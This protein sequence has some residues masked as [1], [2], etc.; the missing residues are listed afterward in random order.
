MHF[1][2]YVGSPS[3]IQPA[4]DRLAI[5]QNY[6]CTK[7]STRT[8]KIQ[9]KFLYV[10]ESKTLLTYFPSA[11][12]VRRCTI[13][14]CSVS[15]ISEYLIEGSNDLFGV[16]I[17]CHPL[18]LSAD[19]DAEDGASF[20]FAVAR[21]QERN[22]LRAA[23]SMLVARAQA[24]RRIG[25][26]IVACFQLWPKDDDEEDDS[27]DD[28]DDD[29]GGPAGKGTT[30]IG[31]DVIYK[32]LKAGNVLCGFRRAEISEA[33]DL[34][35]AR[36]KVACQG[37]LSFEEGLPFPEV[38]RM[39]QS[40]WTLEALKDIYLHI[41][42]KNEFQPWTPQHVR[43]F[44]RELQGDVL[45]NEQALELTRAFSSSGTQWNFADFCA[46][47]C[48]PV[49][50]GWLP[51]LSPPTA[52]AAALVPSSSRGHATRHRAPGASRDDNDPAEAS[53][54]T[55][56]V[57]E[58]LRHRLTNYCI[59]T[60]YN[61]PVP[62]RLADANKYPP[63]PWLYA[64]ALRQG[65]RAVEV[66]FYQGITTDSDPLVVP[67]TFPGHRYTLRDVM[68]EI[69]EAMF[70]TSVL[71]VWLF[72]KPDP[73]VSEPQIIAASRVVKSMLG[74]SLVPDEVASSTLEGADTPAAFIKKAFLVIV[75]SSRA[76]Q[77]QS[78]L[79]LE[80]KQAGNN[81]ALKLAV[82]STE[83]EP[84]DN[85]AADTQVS[86]MLTHL[87]RVDVAF[88]T[89]L[90]LFAKGVQFA[91]INVAAQL[92]LKRSDPDAV[93]RQ[94]SA[95][96]DAFFQQEGGTGYILRAPRTGPSGQS[97]LTTRPGRSNVSLGVQIKVLCAHRLNVGGRTSWIRVS[98]K[99]HGNDNDSLSQVNSS[100]WVASAGFSPSWE[101][102]V[103]KV[104]VNDYT[105]AGVHFILEHTRMKGNAAQPAANASVVA[106]G[107]AA[108]GLRDCRLGYRAIRITQ[109]KDLDFL[110]D[111]RSRPNKMQELALNNLSFSTNNLTTDEDVENPFAPSEEAV[112]IIHIKFAKN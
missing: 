39:L 80:A 104:N 106:V 2:F 37:R 15:R 12:T 52:T 35:V 5:E 53:T 69:E 36:E 18:Q 6:P 40:L 79:N 32:I 25:R 56:N 66:V 19:D 34:S 51:S 44:C 26:M 17:L 42:L 61:F 70:A 54:P 7:V 41:T 107:E 4:I 82:E 59:K 94:S 62:T 10:D 112:L 20:I 83:N 33:F 43:A 28:V 97:I 9:S 85:S 76:A 99:L 16:K 74:A 14:L 92:E 75:S 96:V 64:Q 98:V 110:D 81:T 88:S 38:T 60:A 45:T 67:M 21:E 95:V 72:L 90:K 111:A 84:E 86:G 102:F 8:G 58:H 57:P 24:D 47:L 68:R 71:P 13:D 109:P 30:A 1:Q 87:V 63:L 91:G 50:N 89:P 3:D 105:L 31:V 49:C 22:I 93:A 29:G 46:F 101:S 55:G 108:V 78:S 100:P 48:D 65:Y 27:G 11:K 103:T 77:S 23:L 73:A